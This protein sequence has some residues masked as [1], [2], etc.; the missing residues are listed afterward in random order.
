MEAAAERMEAQL[1]LWSAKIDHLAAKTQA[2][3]VQARFD[4]LMYVDE[5]KALHAIAQ[6]K[7]IEFKAAILAATAGDTKR[8]RL[9]A[10]MKKAWSELDA[11][12]NNPRPSP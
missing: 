9:Q 10:E 5:L 12:F 3:G 7:L 6:A 11:A 8:T 4:A 1:K 2:A